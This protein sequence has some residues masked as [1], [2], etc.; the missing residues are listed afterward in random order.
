MS[1]THRQW[2]DLPPLAH[3][4]CDELI[5]RTHPVKS[6]ILERR[7]SCGRRDIQRAVR[8]LRDDAGLIVC[9]SA[10]GYWLETGDAKAMDKFRKK[11][12]RD[13]LSRM[14]LAHDVKRSRWLAKAIG[15]I[16]A[17]L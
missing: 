4:V 5:M 15:Q 2:A 13:A 3:H 12:L 14:K 8:A 17:N 1:D 16:E 6:R 10:K 9:A 7:F 11:M